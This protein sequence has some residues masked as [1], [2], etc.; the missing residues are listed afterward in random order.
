MVFDSSYIYLRLI[1]LMPYIFITVLLFMNYIYFYFS[2]II[3]SRTRYIIVVGIQHTV[4]KLVNNNTGRP[5]IRKFAGANGRIKNF[6]LFVHCVVLLS[7]SSPSWVT[8]FHKKKLL[9]VPSTCRCT[10]SISLDSKINPGY[11]CLFLFMF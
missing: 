10:K 6:H 2:V 7:L 9:F 8:L 5:N 11:L 1:S 3:A 4:P